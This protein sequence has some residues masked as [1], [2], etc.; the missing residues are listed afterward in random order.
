ME[1]PAVWRLLDTG[2]KLMQMQDI[3]LKF[4]NFKQRIDMEWSVYLQSGD[5]LI[6]VHI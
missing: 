4:G 1:M 6:Q 2:A 3:G 5:C